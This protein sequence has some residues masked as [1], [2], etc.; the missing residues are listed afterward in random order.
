M[1]CP[2]CHAEYR[3]GFYR[4]ADCD[5][6]LVQPEPKPKEP[7]DPNEDPFC[8]FWRGED[9]CLHEELC[10]VLDEVGIPHKTVQRRDHLFNLANYP[11]FELGVPFSFFE[12]AELA[13]RDAFELD[14][15]DREALLALSLPRLLPETREIRK[16]PPI[17]T[18]PDTEAIPGPPSAGGSE[19]AGPVEATAEVWHGDDAAQHEM[20]LAALNENGIAS[21]T[22]HSQDSARI[23]VAPAD[24]DRAREILREIVE[25]APPE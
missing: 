5:V 7:G 22:N 9:A 23:F 3:P 11:S 2:Q 1:I 16:L 24:L 18:P 21:R 13:I 19:P 12:K 20:L 25:G 14:P 8:S 10:T 15:A 4:C 17:L 6:P